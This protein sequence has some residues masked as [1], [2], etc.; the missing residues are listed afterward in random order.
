MQ[1]DIYLI[2]RILRRVFSFIIIT[3]LRRFQQFSLLLTLVLVSE[4]LVILS[5]HTHRII[6]ASKTIKFLNVF[7]LAILLQ[8]TS[9]VI[10]Q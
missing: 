3:P 1:Y 9:A 7:S 2:I 10:H 6:E 4:Y 5:I 8:A